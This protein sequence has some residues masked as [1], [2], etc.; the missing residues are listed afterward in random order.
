M[1]YFIM[2]CLIFFT[3]GFVS[4][5]INIALLIKREE[6]NEKYLSRILISL[7]IS[8]LSMIVMLCVS[9]LKILQII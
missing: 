4:F 5:I 8:A 7:G 9:A 1:N 3:S 6:E 2:A